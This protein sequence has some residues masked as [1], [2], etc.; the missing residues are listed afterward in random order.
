MIYNFSHFASQQLLVVLL[1]IDQ[2]FTVLNLL[3]A[4]VMLEEDI[5]TLDK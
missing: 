4:S 5:S 2:I 3:K 1:A